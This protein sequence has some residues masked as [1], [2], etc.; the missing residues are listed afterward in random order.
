MIR[1]PTF[2]LF[3]C[4]LA[5]SSFVPYMPVCA[6]QEMR[7]KVDYTLANFGHILY[8]RTV[9]GELIIPEDK[10]LCSSDNS[11]TFY[12]FGSDMKKFVLIKRGNCKFT[13]KILNAQKR[14]ADMV[15]IYDYENSASTLS[16]MANDGHGHLVEIPSIFISN[17]DGLKIIKTY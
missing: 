17:A 2:L 16:V 8:G 12:K 14:G 13:K 5:S 6:V 15:I 4:A 1:Q 3:L 10:D 9:V 11:E 7:T